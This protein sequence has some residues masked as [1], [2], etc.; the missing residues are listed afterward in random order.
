MGIWVPPLLENPVNHVFNITV[1]GRP[2]GITVA[3]T[4]HQAFKQATN[5][6]TRRTVSQDGAD[7]DGHILVHNLDLVNL[8]LGADSMLYWSGVPLHGLQIVDIPTK[9]EQIHA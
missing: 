7:F 5:A 9:K 6:L 3:P 1:N 4:F 8:K 2:A